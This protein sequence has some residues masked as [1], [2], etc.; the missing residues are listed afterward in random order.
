MG[1]KKRSRAGSAF[2]V[3]LASVLW[4]V[5]AYAAEIK[6]VSSDFISGESCNVSLSGEIV[7]GD[8]VHLRKTLDGLGTDS[9]LGGNYI[10]LC[11]NS[12]GGSWDQALSMARIVHQDGIGTIVQ[13][14]SYCNSACSIVFMAGTAT[15]RHFS[16]PY[17]HLDASSVLSFHAPYL[18]STS[19]ETS[20]GN[21]AAVFESA[22]R[23]IASLMAIF[24][25]SPAPKGQ[26]WIRPSLLTRMLAKGPTEAFEV[27]TVNDA[28]RLGINLSGL[29]NLNSKLTE[30]MLAYACWNHTWW[31][32]DAEP[33]AA[34][35]NQMISDIRNETITEFDRPTSLAEMTVQINSSGYIWP[36]CKVK[37]KT[38]AVS[39]YQFGLIA[40]SNAGSGDDWVAL[41]PWWMFPG[42]TELRTLASGQ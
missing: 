1:A 32:L 4:C 15:G 10:Q 12:P 19:R 31:S 28:G 17:R 18:L 22:T 13:K 24:D 26:Y 34:T 25:D 3:F 14:D 9:M 2:V 20:I 38:E 27:A 37:Y 7:A 8:A 30:D 6:V 41:A 16:V 29:S 11:L 33:P 39:A 36:T 42:N 40:V 35:V 23:A 5:S 21:D